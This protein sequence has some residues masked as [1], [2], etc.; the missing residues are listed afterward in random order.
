M[1]LDNFFISVLILW[2][3]FKRGYRVLRCIKV[4][5]IV[6]FQHSD[7]QLEF[8]NEFF[9]STQTIGEQLSV[10]LLKTQGVNWLQLPL[11]TQLA[12]VLVTRELSHCYIKGFILCKTCFRIFRRKKSTDKIYFHA[13]WS[14]IKQE[15]Q[16][17]CD[18][19]RPWA[20][21]HIDRTHIR[22]KTGNDKKVSMGT[23]SQEIKPVDLE[24]H[25]F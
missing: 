7:K 9:V 6:H 12:L 16:S 21:K 2:I 20:A 15:A 14:H 22:K 17:H 13:N 24:N 19:F 1:F 5:S 4:W 25:K 23:L 18:I 10:A 8:F 11:A 3:F